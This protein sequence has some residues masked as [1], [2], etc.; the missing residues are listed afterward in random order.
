MHYFDANYAFKLVEWLGSG[1]LYH[2]LLARIPTRHGAGN[3]DPRFFSS[4]SVP[5]P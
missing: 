2:H 4:A 5:T 3:R 1:S